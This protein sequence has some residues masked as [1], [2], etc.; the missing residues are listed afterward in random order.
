MRFRGYVILAYLKHEARSCCSVK[1]A[2]L[3]TWSKAI[4]VFIITEFDFLYCEL[5]D[6]YKINTEK[7]SLLATCI[8]HQT[9]RF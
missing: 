1:I 6:I 5:F 9:I 3:T 2:S 4:V 8:K 7:P